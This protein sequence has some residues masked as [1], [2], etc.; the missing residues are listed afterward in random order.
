MRLL[1]FLSILF[2]SCNPYPTAK[3]AELAI[4]PTIKTVDKRVTDL[5][6]IQKRNDSIFN[7]NLILLKTDNV[8]QKTQ[9]SNLEK[10][11]AAQSISITALIK[12]TVLKARQILLLTRQVTQFISEQTAA[13]TINNTNFYWWKKDT[14]INGIARRAQIKD[15]IWQ[16]RQIYSISKQMKALQLLV[17]KQVP[18]QQLAVLQKQVTTATTLMNKTI[19]KS[20]SVIYINNMYSVGLDS[21]QFIKSPTRTITIRRYHDVL[22]RLTALDGK[23]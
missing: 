11:H 8:L 5:Q 14:L 10:G 17:D 13:N 1:F 2:Y 23:P 15:T 7:V 18:S 9:I 21:S 19:Q 16:A 12:D 20:D 22:N 6:I 4:D 3:R